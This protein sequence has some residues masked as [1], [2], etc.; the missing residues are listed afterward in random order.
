MVFFNRTKKLK[1]AKFS[2]TTFQQ[3]ETFPKQTKPEKYKNNKRKIAN[4]GQLSARVVLARHFRFI[5]RTGCKTPELLRLAR[6][7]CLAVTAEYVSTW[8]DN[9]AP[10]KWIFSR[11]RI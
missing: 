11:V 9:F 1:I 2:F 8:P 3:R 5:P 6:L 7:I 10:R 4:V